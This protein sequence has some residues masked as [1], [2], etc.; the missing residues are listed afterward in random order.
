MIGTV[1]G[2]GLA[3]GPTVA[4]VLVGGLGW[5]WVFGLFA[6]VAVGLAGLSL[7]TRDSRSAEGSIDLLGTI[8]YVVGLAAAQI[9]IL[10][11][12]E[13]GWSSGFVWV[14]LSGGVLVLGWF[15][16]RQRRTARPLLDV[17]LFADRHIAGWLLVC[18][19]VA[20]G[21]MG[22]LATMPTFLQAA[23]GWTA[24][25]AGMVMLALTVPVILLPPVTAALVQRGWS[26]RLVLGVA[27]AAV[28]LGNTML[29]PLTPERGT[30]YLVGSLLLLGTTSGLLAGLI[31]PQTMAR[32][33]PDRLGMA[34]GVLNT[35]RAGGNTVA[36]TLFSAVL[37]ARAAAQL[38]DQDRAG[39]VVGGDIVSA[40]QAGVLAS[41]LGSTHGVVA[42]SCLLLGVAALALTRP[43]PRTVIEPVRDDAAMCS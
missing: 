6:G 28:V 20:V 16:A 37:V 42:L 27:V 31:D 38:G 2:I 43:E 35:V 39:R 1:V 7:L 33:G 11:T 3:A 25:A 29:T 21:T 22:A 10:Q 18:L 19:M 12:T 15:L 23:S 34:S 40:E 36:L 8:A 24:T 17:R 26:P 9:G 5:R 41:A 30:V 32:V 13:R 4:G 14:P